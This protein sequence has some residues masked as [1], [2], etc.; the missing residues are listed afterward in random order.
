MIHDVQI[1]NGRICQIREMVLTAA[2]LE[3]S[4]EAMPYGGEKLI[5]D[6]CVE[7]LRL[8]PISLVFYSYVFESGTIPSGDTLVELYL[9]QEEYFSYVPQEKVEVIYDRQVT[10]VELEGLRARV[11]RTYPSLVR[12]FH[13]YLMALESNLFSLVQYSV[14]RDFEHGIDLKV[15]VGER[16]C[17]VA[18]YLDSPRARLFAS[19]KRFRHPQNGLVRLGLKSG[20]EKRVGDYMLYSE[21]HIRKLYETVTKG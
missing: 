4:L 2:N 9:N 20:Q 8:P 14:S 15:S 3:K 19:I 6:P 11:L 5:K 13:F 7:N 16:S 21:S 1:S 10:L 17:N 12:D 18:L